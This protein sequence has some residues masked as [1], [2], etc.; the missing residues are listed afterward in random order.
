MRKLAIAILLAISL[1]SCVI[2]Q[3]SQNVEIK[4]DSTY[5]VGI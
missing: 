2:V 3:D 5:K 1:S 4:T